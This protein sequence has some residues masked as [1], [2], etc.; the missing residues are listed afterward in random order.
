MTADH[1]TRSG[2]RR[3]RVLKLGGAAFLTTGA[4]G[5]VNADVDGQERADEDTLVFGHFNIELLT[6]EKAQSDDHDQLRAA[7]EVV[8]R[9][10]EPDVLLIQELDNNFQQGERTQTHNGVSFLRKYLN[11]PQG[12]D[13]DGVDYD[14]FYA[15]ES[16]TG[17]PS[18]MDYY[19]SGEVDLEPGDDPY[20]NDSWGYGEY[21]GQYAMGIY[22][23]YPIDLSNV[24]TLRRF[25]WKD[26]PDDKMPMDRSYETYLTEAERR[27]FRLSSKTHADVPI[28][29]DGETIHAVIAHPTPPV[30]DGPENLNGRRCH[31]EVRL[32]GDYVRGEEYVYDDDGVEGGLS[33]DE[34]FVVMGD[35]NAEPGQE[36]SFDA[37]T[38]HL[39]DNPRVNAENL[40]TSQGGREEG[41]E[42]LTSGFG[43]QVDYV[44]PS[45]E[46]DVVDSAVVYP[47]EETDDQ[48]F[49]ETVLQASDHYMVWTEL[50][51]R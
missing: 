7:A 20:A 39:L 12:S 42:H 10:P 40:P 37:A 25:R 24:R 48:A 3:R 4:V 8:Q 11:V 26:V 9:Q 47:G 1:S 16:N 18:G 2:Y 36:E 17:V 38:T 41:N 15:P 43:S 34:R 29:V 14:Y 23:K 13:L 30:F 35:M 49:R 21:P 22:S 45:T 6:T 31:G 44:L 51:A 33:E 46:F 32:V 27:R 19:K 50:D 28:E 5:S